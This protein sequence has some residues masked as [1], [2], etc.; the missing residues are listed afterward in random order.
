MTTRLVVTAQ[1]LPEGRPFTSLGREAWALL[2]LLRAGPKGCTA[3]DNPG[4]RWSAY[5]HALRHECG[6]DI[7]TLREIHQGPFPGNHAR[8]C[9]RSAVEILSRNDEPVARAA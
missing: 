1:R 2:E 7:E 6:L 5:I 9:L 4:L 3:I 8:Y